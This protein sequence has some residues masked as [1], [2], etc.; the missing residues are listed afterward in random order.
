MN[1]YFLGYAGAGCLLA[2]A[3]SSLATEISRLVPWVWQ[4]LVIV[5]GL[6]AL[7]FGSWLRS[8][9]SKEELLLDEE[10]QQRLTL[11]F[12]LFLLVNII[13]GLGVNLGIY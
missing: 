12:A 9:E 1:K 10:K 7:F 3:L 13:V 2:I 8:Q 6:A 5:W 11:Y 4:A